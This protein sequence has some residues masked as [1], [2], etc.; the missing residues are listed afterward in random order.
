MEVSAC[1][2]TNISEAFQDLILEIYNGGDREVDFNKKSLL[3][4]TNLSD[5]LRKK[6]DCC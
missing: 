6:K 3:K 2:G 5:D 1:E 4:P